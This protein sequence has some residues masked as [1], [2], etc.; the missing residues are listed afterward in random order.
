M[1]PTRPSASSGQIGRRCTVPPS[2]ATTSASQCAGAGGGGSVGG[3]AV[4]CCSVTGVVRIQ[5]EVGET[6]A[7]GAQDRTVHARLGEGVP[8]REAGPAALGHV[9][10]RPRA[11][12]STRHVLAPGLGDLRGGGRGRAPRGGAPGG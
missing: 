3:G 2:A 10:R 8:V 1:S 12:T 5:T 7:A 11:Q 6:G 9:R 4:G